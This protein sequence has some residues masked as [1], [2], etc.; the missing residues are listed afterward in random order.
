MAR[1]LLGSGL[2][3]ARIQA[4]E[5]RGTRLTVTEAAE[6]IGVDKSTL[7]R[8]ETADVSVG[9]LQLRAACDYYELDSDTRTRLENLR[10]LAAQPGWWDEGNWPD[11]VAAMLSME[12]SAVRRRSFNQNALPGL[13]Q[14]PEVARLTIQA[15]EQDQLSPT[16]LD[17]GV[18][19]RMERQQRVA[20]GPGREAVYLIDEA[21][22]L[23]MPGTV[24]VR[25]A[26]V[27]RLL[28]PPANC[29]VLIVPTSAG[30]LPVGGSFVIFDF[31]SDI[32]KSA[33]YVEGHLAGRNLIE[34]KG[35]HRYETVYAALVSK[36]Y[37]PSQTKRFL[38]DLQR[39]I[40]GNID[41]E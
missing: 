6:G 20:D 26:Q 29:K 34:T 38:R 32:I 30:P 15:V 9:K 12:E 11:V 10:E 39:S 24:A 33:V 17:R 3:K 23:R 41:D 1:L 37:S 2:E 19:L 36:A 28:S 25:R 5:R 8:W 14:T 27:R 16:E 22:L 7:R 13:L 4:G 35:V 40:G 18:E 21:A 31:A